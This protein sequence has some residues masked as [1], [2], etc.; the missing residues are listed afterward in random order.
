M[1]ECTLF[2]FVCSEC[3]ES[4]EVNGSMRETLVEEGCVVCGSEVT[5]DQFSLP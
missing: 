5:P 1:L 4:F 2:R 3:G